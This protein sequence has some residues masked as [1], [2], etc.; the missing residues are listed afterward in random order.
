M[1]YEI[2]RD[3]DPVSPREN[4]NL[5]TI[6]YVSRNYVLGD[7]MVS[8]DELENVMNNK[9]NIV[10]PVYAYIH[11]GVTVNTT[12]FHCPWDSGQSGCIYVSKDKVR[13]WFSVKKLTKKLQLQ[14][15]DRLRA[16]IEE[17]DRYLNGDVYGYI[18]RDDNGKEVDSCFGFI[19]E[20]AVKEAAEDSLKFFTKEVA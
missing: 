19:G 10:L 3:D 12:G 5:G 16:E 8:R 4:D 18:I 20:E 17:Y 14:I 9:N 6:L 11:S 13:Q 15:Q 1:N 2:V 7:T